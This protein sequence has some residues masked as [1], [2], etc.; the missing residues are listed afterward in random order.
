[1]YSK[2]HYL[3]ALDECHQKAHLSAVS[4]VSLTTETSLGLIYQHCGHNLLLSTYTNV[5]YSHFKIPKYITLCT[6]KYSIRCTVLLQNTLVYNNQD[7]Y[8]VV[9]FVF[10]RNTSLITVKGNYEMYPKY[11]LYPYL[12]ATT[13]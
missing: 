5:K 10:I 9:S 8:S 13:C 12:M 4:P 11:K 6:P 7:M 2:S 1:M 3:L